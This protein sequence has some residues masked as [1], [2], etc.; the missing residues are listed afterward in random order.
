[1]VEKLVREGALLFTIGDAHDAGL[2]F[3]MVKYMLK[4]AF[5]KEENL[6]WLNEIKIGRKINKTSYSSEPVL[7]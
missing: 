5:A 1:M 3:S 2:P 4:P 6:R 7:Y